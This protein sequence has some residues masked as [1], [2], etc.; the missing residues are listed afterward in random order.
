MTLL[1]SITIALKYTLIVVI[2][3]TISV[4]L[5]SCFTGIE[6]TPRITLKDVKRNNAL[7]TKESLLA[8]SIQRP[9]FSQWQ[10]G[11]RLLVTDDRFSLLL[12]GNQSVSQGDTLTY[13]GFTPAITVTADTATILNFRKQRGEPID[14]KLDRSPQKLCS[15]SILDIPFT[16]DLAMVDFAKNLLCQRTFYIL[17]PL[18]VDR[19]GNA[20]SSTKFT[21]ITITDVIPGSADYPLIV[22][23][24]EVDGS[25]SGIMMTNGSMR[26]ATRNFDRLFSFTDPRLKYNKINDETWAHIVNGDIVIGM[27]TEEA[28][29][30]TGTPRDVKKSHDGTS[31]FERWSFDNGT[32]IMFTDGLVS[33]F[34][35]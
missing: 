2:I 24:T 11:H 5:H 17:S 20:G 28:L 30:A 26:T 7:A 10:P 19:K 15:D 8:D 13:L 27:T 21:P 31:Y 34:R 16:I 35:L 32:Y 25:E 14:F 3:T 22:I 12:S 23:F 18:R 9:D 4:S 29:L 33:S 1:R 6:S